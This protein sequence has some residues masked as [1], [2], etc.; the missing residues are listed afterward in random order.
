[1]LV[2]LRE[3][4]WCGGE[5]ISRAMGD[6][7]LTQGLSVNLFEVQ[8]VWWL[9]LGLYFSDK[10]NRVVIVANITHQ[11]QG[12]VPHWPTKCSYHFSPAIYRCGPT[13]YD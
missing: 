11:E 12:E 2:V 4:G 8:A 6:L 5:F 1:V 7:C 3:W 10:S 9:C 13:H